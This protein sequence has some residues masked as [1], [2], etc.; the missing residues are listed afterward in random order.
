MTYIDHRRQQWDG[1][2]IWLQTLR[3]L[4]FLYEL[5]SWREKVCLTETCLDFYQSQKLWQEQQQWHHRRRLDLD[6]L[7]RRDGSIRII[8]ACVCSVSPGDSCDY[9][10][11]SDTTKHCGKR[12]YTHT[13]TPDV[14]SVNNYSLGLNVFWAD[15]RR[16]EPIIYC[17]S[18]DHNICVDRSP[19][20]NRPPWTRWIYNRSEVTALMN[21]LRKTQ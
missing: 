13:H 18:H 6:Q 17:W 9:H 15:V 21:S 16:F 10:H 2:I 4:V 5:W 8:R 11:L 12:K 7:R 14:I 1:E 20:H 3:R 19:H